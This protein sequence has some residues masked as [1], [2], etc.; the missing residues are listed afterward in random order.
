MVMTRLKNGGGIWKIQYSDNGVNF[1]D[2][3]IMEKING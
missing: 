1:K 3:G 2:C